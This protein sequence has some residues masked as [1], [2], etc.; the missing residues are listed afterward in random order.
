[1]RIHPHSYTDLAFTLSLLVS[2]VLTAS[3]Q[4]LAPFTA[5]LVTNVP[6]GGAALHPQRALPLPK[7]TLTELSRAAQEMRADELAASSNSVGQAQSARQ[8]R[9]VP[10]GLRAEFGLLKAFFPA[11]PAG[12]ERFRVTTPDGR[13]LAFQPRFLAWHD[14]STDERWLLADVTNRVGF[15]V[16]SGQVWY[17]NA[18]GSDVRADL[19][20]RYSRYLLEQD[21]VIR[22][23]LPLPESAVAENLRL[24]VWTEWFDSTPVAR[25]PQLID[26]RRSQDGAAPALAADTGCWSS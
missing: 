24:E 4:R 5:P 18:F 11:D 12:E 15:I 21:I 6:A 10:G 14:T 9:A 3:A 23:R 7:P 20:F 13:A 22:E 19:R 8:L 26:L 1:M 17:T 2:T 25:E 16:P